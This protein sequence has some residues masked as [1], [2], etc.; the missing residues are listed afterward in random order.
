MSNP[1]LSLASDARAE[2]EAQGFLQK[3]LGEFDFPKTQLW[4]SAAGPVLYS[5]YGDKSAENLVFASMPYGNDLDSPNMQLRLQAQAI[6]LPEGSCVIGVQEV[7]PSKLPLDKNQYK[8]LKSGS[9]LPF[10]QRLLGLIEGLRPSHDQ[11]VSLYGFSMGADITAEAA[12]YALFDENGSNVQIDN[13]GIF[14]PARVEK[15]SRGKV[16]GAFSN[17]GPDLYENVV[18]SN[19]QALNEHYGIDPNADQETEKKA[20]DKRI[21]AKV[22]KASIGHPVKNLVLLKAFTNDETSKKLHRITAKIH[23]TIMGVTVGRAK[24]STITSNLIFSFGLAA[25]AYVIPG[26]HAIADDL[27]VSAAMLAKTVG[28]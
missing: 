26:T 28:L 13:I 15:R 27:A 18:T 14:E 9:M 20:F 3:P 19:S 21:A 1:I 8:E 22:I 24:D 7:S 11:R 25:E 6:A 17:S 4:T 16:L 23:P 12:D 5:V 2:F 10:G